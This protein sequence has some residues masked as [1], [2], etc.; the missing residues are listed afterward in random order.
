MGSST[1]IVFLFCF[2]TA[3]SVIYC[4]NNQIN[5][6]IYGADEYEFSNQISFLLEVKISGIQLYIGFR[7]QF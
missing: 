3:Q 1:L 2:H 7:H 5:A 4:L 6:S